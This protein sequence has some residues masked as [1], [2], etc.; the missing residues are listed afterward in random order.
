M[1]RALLIVLDSVGVGAAPDAADFHDEGSNTVG[2]IAQACW[3]GL[4]DRAGLRQGP[5]HIPHLCALGMAHALALSTGI[6]PE[7]IPQDTA[8]QGQ[9]GIAQEVSRGKDSPSGHWEISGC[10]VT[11]TWHHF[12]ETEPCFPDSLIDSLIKDNNLPGILGN[13]HASGMAIIEEYG[14]Q[15]MASGKP[16]IY[17]S[18]DSVFQIA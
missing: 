2:H 11:F 16:I 13:K 17:T 4:G 18:A 15:H 1:P 5:L 10:P 7:G 3:R 6:F 9:W 12:P 14:A 8:I